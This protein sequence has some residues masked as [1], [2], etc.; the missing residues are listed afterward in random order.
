MA[1]LKIEVKVFIVQSLACFDNPSQLVESV[2]KEFGLAMP[3]QQVKSPDPTK[4]NVKRLAQNGCTCSTP[5]AND[6][7][8]KSEIS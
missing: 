8:G 3:R 4:A 5:T 1:A 6:P 7:R 2:K